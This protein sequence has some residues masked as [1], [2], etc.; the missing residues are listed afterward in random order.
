VNPLGIDEIVDLD[1]Y[2]ALREDY[3]ARVRDAKQARRLAVG[4]R[5]TLLFENRE[6]VRFQVQEMLRVERIR[7]AARVQHELDVYNELVPGAG[8]L[9]ATL[10]I[11]I[12]DTRQIRSELDRLLGI[13]A[14]VFL[15]LGAGAGA[16]RIRARFDERQLEEDRISA[17]HYLRFDVGAE[18]AA[19]VRDARVPV[20]V[21]IEHAAYAASAELTPALRAS[22]VADLDGDPPPLLVAPPGTSVAASNTPELSPSGRVRIRRAELPA[23]RGHVVVEPVE[24]VA[25]W[26][27]AR[28]DLEAELLAEVK[29]RAAEVAA[30]HGRC[31]VL[32]DLDAPRLRW[33][34]YAPEPH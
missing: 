7:G 31:R 17:V 22:L 12:T 1:A 8:E 33:H 21:A 18:A 25:S 24:D 15:V 4:D 13:D 23:G 2:E 29:R 3:R 20:R 19:R 32:C 16:L 11:E 9:S 27:D 6:T 14:C 26:L 5:V 30:R 34:V 28:P 10:L